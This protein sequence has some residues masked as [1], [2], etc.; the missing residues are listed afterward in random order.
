VA[1]QGA[2]NLILSNPKSAKQ[3]YHTVLGASPYSEGALL[4]LASFLGGFLPGVTEF[5]TAKEFALSEP[6][7][8][9][10]KD[11]HDSAPPLVSE[12]LSSVS[13]TPLISGGVLDGEW[14]GRLDRAFVGEGVSG[15]GS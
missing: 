6:T 5:L 3:P 13:A 15:L 11:F 10:A 1:K 2:K 9:A 8:N 14:D 7:S 4:L 12:A